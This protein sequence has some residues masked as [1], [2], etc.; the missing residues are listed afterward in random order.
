MSGE[1][2]EMCH[3][4]RSGRATPRFTRA[5][6]LRMLLPAFALVPMITR[7]CLAGLF[8]ILPMSAFCE[9]PAPA[10]ASIEV[11][12]T[13]D[14]GLRTY[15][16]HSTA[17]LRDNVPADGRREI[18]EAP[19]AAT[20]R[21]G[22]PFFDALYALAVHEARLNSVAS[23]KDG[24][25]GN[26]EP[27]ALE[28]FQTGEFWTYVWT[29]DL[30]Y[31]VDLSLG[32]FDPARAVSSL[33]FKTSTLKPTVSGGFAHQIIQDTGSGGSYPVSSDRV[34]WALGAD[35]ALR[36][37]DGAERE[38]FL[39]RVFPILRDSLELDRVLLFD[40]ADGLYRG[41]QSFL[42]WRE[43]TYP[44]WTKEHTLPLAL[45]KALSTNV[46][47]FIALG[48]A[49]DYAARL[50][51][52]DA[53]AR[54]RGWAEA[55][56]AAINAHFWDAGAGLYSAF[57]LSD[58]GPAVR[59][60]RYDLL[61]L[62]LA[63]L[64]GVA[65]P[66]QADA[67]LRAYPTGPHG[68]SVVWPQERAV[69]IYHNQGIWPFVTAYWLKAARA[70]GHAAAI[71]HALASLQTQAAENLSNMENFDWVSGLAEVKGAERD[72]PVVNSRRQLWSVAGYLSAVQDIV[73]G[74]ETTWDGLRFQPAVTAHQRR[75]TF[76]ASAQ[77][78]WRDFVWRGTRHTVRVLLPDVPVGATGLCR[79]VR[80]TLNG[81]EA[82]TDFVP[83]GL[84]AAHNVW[85]IQLAAPDA[86]ARGAL[87]VADIRDERSYFAPVQPE[88]NDAEAAV[89]RVGGRTVLRFRAHPA[90]D[91]VTLNLYRD[92]RRVATGWRGTE[93]TDVEAT[94]GRVNFYAAEA[95]D[96]RTGTVSHLTPS[97][98]AAAADRELV[99]PA[100]NFR[101]HGGKL[102]D[103]RLTEWGAREDRAETEFIAVRDGRHLLTAA[104]AN[105]SGPINTGIACGVKRLEVIHALSGDV[106]A[107]GYLVMPQL[108]NWERIERSAPVAADLRAGE[109]YL[110]RVSED[111]Q[112]RN[113]SY[114]VHNARYTSWPGGG[115]AHNRVTLASLH[116]LAL[117]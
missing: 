79:V 109:R 77:V 20:V 110:L 84:L 87:R 23:I 67:I 62:S 76:A 99:L 111:E 2:P 75:A 71:D 64:H 86:P 13:D 61:G 107:T 102:A 100:T 94:D 8:A 17:P 53:A 113:M 60:D 66:G 21:S 36:A 49:A 48:R 108:A 115:E 92:G 38:A 34:V 10:R 55:L 83:H 90:G 104:Y 54:Y 59:S 57:L 46:L 101:A 43:Q 18:A 3:S 85:E 7:R 96:A 69:P 44:L 89:A 97:R 56:K 14:A 52:P 28:A 114:L 37:L 80:V 70:A 32:A 72:G 51:Q 27:L 41:E 98:R 91:G 47:H 5:R 35:A 58:G 26:G 63:I 25:Y 81:S 19:G 68:P 112:A 93:W 88:W 15:G 39:A 6:R 11:L 1:H 31:S 106:V 12:R 33:L 40:R 78:E 50:G 82:G 9:L 22:N 116:A 24:A 73:F 45:S 29:R 42:D 74:L 4:R 30:A 103:G 65:S 117:E 95:V 16:M 105:G